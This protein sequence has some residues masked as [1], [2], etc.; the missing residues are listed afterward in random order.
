MEINNPLY[1]N[2]GMHVIT[3]LFTVEEGKF[4]V[5]LV[6]R[7]N[8]PYKDMW[9]LVGGAC[10]NNETIEEAMAREMYEKTGLKNINTTFFKVYSNPNRSPLM[11]MFA[12][13]FVG[14]IDCKKVNLLRKTTKTKD[15]DWFLL[16]R[17]PPLGYDH[18]KILLDAIEFLKE[19]IFD[20]QITISLFSKTFTLPEIYKAYQSILNK[21]I[22]RRNFRKTL[23]QN[24][25][26]EPT[27]QTENAIG[28]KPA[29]L[30][31]F[32][33]SKKTLKPF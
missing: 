23:L 10:Y 14:V 13:V 29:K 26:I 18:N 2:Q 25:I 11:R 20:S 4:K 19:K 24:H 32:C 22:D 12:V 9:M 27:G 31:R 28:K 21:D 3:A 6:K 33:G 7:N 1:K 8:Q 15:A 17:I 16:D 30:Y 5:L